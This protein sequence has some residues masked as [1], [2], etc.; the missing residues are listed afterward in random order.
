MRIAMIIF[1][2]LLTLA[3][4]ASGAM[5]LRKSPQVIEGMTHVGVK[6]SQVPLLGLIEIAGGAGLLIGFATVTLG[7]LAAAGLVLYFLGAMIAH[8]RIKDS[9]KIFA[10]AAFLLIVS[11]VTFVLQVNR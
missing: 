8:L 7:R 9:V 4:F 10:P 6:E 2:S 1:S 11:V 3:V 5:K